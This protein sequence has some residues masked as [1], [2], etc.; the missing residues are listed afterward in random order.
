MIYYLMSLWIISWQQFHVL[1][2][3]LIENESIFEQKF[4]EKPVETIAEPIEE[5]IQEIEPVQIVTI[6]ARIDELYAFNNW[7]QLGDSGDDVAKL[8]E[9]MAQ[10]NYYFGDLDGDF[11]EETRIWL[12]DTLISECDWPESTSGIMWPQAISC[13]N[14]IVV[15]YEEEVTP[16]ENVIFEEEIFTGEDILNLEQDF[17]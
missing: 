10:K 5:F 1:D 14:S 13:I 16:E 3:S 2:E 7:L 11:D 9:F 6:E 4:E 17:E 15:T 8:Q 12:R